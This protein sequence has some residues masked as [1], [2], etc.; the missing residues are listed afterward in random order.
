MA[1]GSEEVGFNSD[2]C[3]ELVSELVSS[4]IINL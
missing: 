1:E 3:A 4:L 2:L